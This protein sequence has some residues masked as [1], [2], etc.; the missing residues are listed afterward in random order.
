MKIEIKYRYSGTTI[1]EGDYDSLMAAMVDAV[2]RGAD[3]RRA[4]LSEASLR[5]ANLS[6]ASLSGA[7]LRGA[8][9]RR[10]DLRRANL[11][12]ASLRGANLSGADLSGA[13]LRGAS[14][15]EANLSGA[16][17][18][19][20][21]LYGAIGLPELIV[22]RLHTRIAEAIG[23][24]GKRLNMSSWHTCKTTHCRGGHAIVLASDAGRMLEHFLGSEGAATVIYRSTYPDEPVPDFHASNEKAMADIL[25]CAARETAQ[26]G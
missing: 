4:D 17:L 12:E 8:D 25:A 16:N 3:L 14:L 6:G 10:A 11:S 2:S 18:Y 19:G 21:D 24:D 20:A 5:E 15:R 26:T 13:D 23:K 9:L 7:N 1:F 22:P